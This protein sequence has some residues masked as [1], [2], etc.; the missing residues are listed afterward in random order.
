MSSGLRG[1]GAGGA[2][3]GG[4]GGVGDAAGAGGATGAA[5]SFLSQAAPM[6]SRSRTARS[7]MVEVEVQPLRRMAPRSTAVDQAEGR[8]S[9][10]TPVRPRLRWVAPVRRQAHGFNPLGARAPAKG[11]PDV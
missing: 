1:G 9:N 3:G 10:L 4:G 11:G 6:P 2:G 7:E 5:A 8:R